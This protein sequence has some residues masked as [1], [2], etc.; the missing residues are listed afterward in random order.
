VVEFAMNNAWNTGGA[1]V[2][3]A[4]CTVAN[5]LDGSGL[6]VNGLG[7][8]G[9]ADGWTTF[10]KN[11]Q[12]GVNVAAMASVRLD[13]CTLAGNTSHNV[14]ASCGADVKLASCTVADSLDGSGLW[15]DGLGTDVRAHGR[16]TFQKNRQCGVYVSAQ[17]S[18]RLDNF[19]VAG[20]IGH[21][22]QAS[23]GAIV[24]L[25]SCTVADSLDGSGLWVG[26]EGT[27]LEANRQTNI[28]TNRQCGVDVA[29]ARVRL[30]DYTVAG[31][32]GDNVQASDG[33]VELA[34]CTV[35]DSLEMSGLAVYGECTY[36]LAQ[37]Q[38]FEGIA[39]MACTYGQFRPC[40]W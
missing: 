32:T 7:T 33:C 5:S 31:N 11:D 27:V 13:N 38:R 19:T 23:R 30:V 22:V 16:T 25:A 14:Q 37:G 8:R 4:N 10:Q 21:N 17:A 39:C 29:K 12:L 9:K 40:I 34:S 15:V 6:W 36:V 18:V 20:N 28:Q 1:I 24:K 2:K 35:A 3:L 26:G